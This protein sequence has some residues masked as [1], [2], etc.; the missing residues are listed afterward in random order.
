MALTVWLFGEKINS[1]AGERTRDL[2]IKLRV[3]YQLSY[4]G[5]HISPQ[6]WLLFGILLEIVGLSFLIEIWVFI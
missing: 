2:S 6:N 5:I 1:S 3:L 4:W